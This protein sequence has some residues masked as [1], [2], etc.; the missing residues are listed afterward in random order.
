MHGLVQHVEEPTRGE[1]TLDLIMSDFREPVKVEVHPP[2]GKPDPAVIIATFPAQLHREQRNRRTVWRNKKADWHRLRHFY[3]AMDWD[4]LFSNDIDE[5]SCAVT[6]KITEGMR[7]FIPSRMLVTRPSDPPRWTPE[8]AE[9]IKA[10]KQA[11]L[12]MRSHPCQ[13]TQES[14]Q[15]CR[16][17]ALQCIATAQA[18]H[19]SR[20][21]DRL[22][23]GCSNEKEWWSTMKQASG[24]GRNSS[25]PTI[26]DRHGNEHASNRSKAE[27]FGQYFADKCTLMMTS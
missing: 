5:Y 20:L 27:A 7:K 21:C 15:R 10:K 24:E 25:I 2:L 3:K 1:N 4:S 22:R 13:A 26:V 14:Y 19:T 23:R 11:W 12:Q 9:V 17:A 8:C 18:I 16:N 6:S